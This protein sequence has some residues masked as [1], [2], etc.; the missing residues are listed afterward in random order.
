ML[1]TVNTFNGHNINDGANYRA[2]LLNPHGGPSA[3]PVYIEQA[4]ADS[5]DAGTYTVQ[6]QTKVL[7][8]EI[9]DKTNKHA[10]IAQLKTWFKRGTDGLL[11]VTFGDD[12]TTYQ[13]DCRAV[14]VNQNPQ[15]PKYFQVILQT[16]FSAWRAVTETTEPTWTVTGT[17]DTQTIDVEGKDDTYLSLDL[18]AVDGPSAGYL[19]QNMYR[20]P[21]TPGVLHGWIPWCITVDTATLVTAGKMQADC[22]DLRII[23][24][25][26]GKEKKRWIVNPNNVATKVWIIVNLQKGFSLTSGAAVASSGAIDYIQFTIN[27]DT[28][29]KISQMPKTGIVY[30]N[31]EWFSYTNTDPINCRLMI[32]QRGLFGTT[33]E[34]HSSGVTFLYIQN[35]LLMRYGNSSVSSPAST[36]ALYDQHKPLINLTSSSNTSWVWTASDLFFDPAYP[37]RFPQWVFARQALGRNSKIFYVKQ[38]A[39]SGDPAIG[40]KVA[41]FDSFAPNQPEVITLFAKLYRAAGITSCSFTGDKYRSN[42][43]WIGLAALRRSADGINWFNLWTEATPGS[44]ASWTTWTRNSVS[45]AT[46]SRFLQLIL[47]GTYP[48]SPGAYAAFEAL[49]ATINFNSSN[50]PTGAFLG[51]QDNYPLVVTIENQTTGESIQLDYMMRLTKT[52]SIDGENNLVQYNGFN[53]FDSVTMD[54][55][56]R[57]AFIRLKGGVTNT[58]AISG[59]DLGE[60]DIDMHYYARRL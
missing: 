19:Y 42:A 52:F 38:D 21:N 33:E 29:L 23:D 51:E 24:M 22:D 1:I 43:N 32:G 39:E 20:L 31:N 40:F 54:D 37:N 17:S 53:A 47:A 60:L 3:Q 58:I 55:E 45:V 26:T 27:D 6:T 34:S 57:P 50:I 2:T 9:L 5:I 30:H 28:K 56:G 13:M 4:E 16:G 8:V 18:T 35:P 11:V 41:S 48:F 46:G 25:N 49:T 59:P 14:S 12:N 15:H 44:A 10:L 7:N 36:D